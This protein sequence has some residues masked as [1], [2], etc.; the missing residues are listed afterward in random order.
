M[1]SGMIADSFKL[2]E[3]FLIALHMTE[4]LQRTRPDKFQLPDECNAVVG[5]W[6]LSVG[7]TPKDLHVHQQAYPVAP[8][9]AHRPYPLS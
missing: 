4:C 6:T 5:P 2:I 1:G 8:R 3:H 7:A 9:A